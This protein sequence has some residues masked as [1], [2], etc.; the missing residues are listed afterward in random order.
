MLIGY[1]TIRGLE[2]TYDFVTVVPPTDVW[3][4][5]MHGWLLAIV[6]LIAAC[7]GLGRRFE[8]PDGSPTKVLP[9]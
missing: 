9:R 7:T 2:E 3:P 5:V 8:A 6:M 1:A 4:F